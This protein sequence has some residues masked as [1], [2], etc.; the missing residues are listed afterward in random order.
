[1]ARRARWLLFASLATGACRPTPQPGVN[2][3]ASSTTAASEVAASEVAVPDVMTPTPPSRPSSTASSPAASQEPAD[4]V[5]TPTEE[6]P[7]REHMHRRARRLY[8]AR[9]TRSLRDGFQCPA[10]PASA[11]PCS[12][13]AT[14]DL[15]PGGRI[16]SFVF[17][18]CGD[19]LVDSAAQASAQS[20]VGTSAPLAPNAYPKMQPQTFTVT[21]VCR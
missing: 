11:P 21:Y 13:S 8:L 6:D 15:D 18:A 5:V 12:P 19:A 4:D 17:E 20:K 16:T 9:L 1:M 7:L 2:A 10:R 14:F 3:E